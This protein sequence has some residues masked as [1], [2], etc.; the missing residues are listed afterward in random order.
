LVVCDD[1]R[2]FDPSSTRDEQDDHFGLRSLTD[3][4][5]VAGARLDVTSDSGAGTTVLLALKGGR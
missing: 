5:E 3:L 4:A 1:G 2:G